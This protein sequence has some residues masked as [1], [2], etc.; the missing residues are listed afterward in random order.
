[1]S[2]AKNIWKSVEVFVLGKFTIWNRGLNS[3]GEKE[4]EKDENRM[5]LIL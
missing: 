2:S 1:M 3:K 5:S 4:L